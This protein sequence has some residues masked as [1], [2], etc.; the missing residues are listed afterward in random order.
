MNHGIKLLCADG[1]QRLCVPVL[2]EYIADMEEQWLLTNLVRQ[3]CPKCSHRHD[4]DTTNDRPPVE[5]GVQSIQSQLQTNGQLESH[6][7]RRY[8]Q[9]WP[10]TDAFRYFCRRRGGRFY[11]MHNPERSTSGLVS[12]VI[13]TLGGAT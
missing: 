5:R 7:N 10:P 9:S 8:V 6:Q 3:T 2:C 4:T 12:K 1:A 11:C 13:S